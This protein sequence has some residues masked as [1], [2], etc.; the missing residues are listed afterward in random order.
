ERETLERTSG[1]RRAGCR[2]EESAIDRTAFAGAAALVAEPDRV[3]LLPVAE[4]ATVPCETRCSE[5]ACGVGPTEL[6]QEPA[7]HTGQPVDHVGGAGVAQAI[8][9]PEPRAV[10][11]GRLAGT[12]RMSSA[13]IHA[14]AAT[15]V[16]GDY[17]VRECA[18]RGFS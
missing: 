11:D 8:R 7:R 1:A 13:S 6:N 17:S 16:I 5:S 4:A 14:P 10:R 18:L 9:K 3:G 2:Q 15:P 12:S